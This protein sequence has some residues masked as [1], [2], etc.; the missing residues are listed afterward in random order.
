MEFC[1]RRGGVKINGYLCR[2]A[3]S[4][5]CSE[6]MRVK[7]VFILL[8][9]VAVLLASG[10]KSGG[11]AGYDPAAD[12][13]AQLDAALAEAQRRGKNVLVQV[14]GSWCPWCVRL[15]DLFTR[16]EQ[17]R[18][19]LAENYVWV[20]LY[21]GRENK[22]ESALARLGDL[23]GYGYPVL[24][25]LSR[26]GAVLHVQNTGELEEG[27]GYSRE[28][29]KAFLDSYYAVPGAL[30]SAGGVADKADGMGEGTEGGVNTEEE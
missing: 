16:D 1:D 23:S 30:E 9:F 8:G 10:C 28:K 21:Y 19:R 29:V 14:G 5:F 22:N 24:V 18:G 6:E 26:E 4:V 3:V 17:L 11:N 25:V 27:Q 15:H 13:N 2:I 7:G 20:Q 12:A